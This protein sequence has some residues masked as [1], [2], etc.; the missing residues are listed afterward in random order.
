MTENKKQLS[1]FGGFTEIKNK[2]CPYCN[3]LLKIVDSRHLLHC[4]N[5]RKTLPVKEQNHLN[6]LDSILTT[7]NLYLPKGI[8]ELNLPNGEKLDFIFVDGK[9]CGFLSQLSKILREEYD[10]TKKRYYRLCKEELAPNYYGITYQKRITRK[11]LLRDFGKG[12]NVPTLSESSTYVLLR[13][14][15]MIYLASRATSNTS[16]LTTKYLIDYSLKA[17][18]WISDLIYKLG[19]CNNREFLFLCA[20]LRL[21]Y[22]LDEITPQR[23][24]R[25]PNTTRR[26][27]FRLH[28]GELLVEIDAR[29]LELHDPLRDKTT[30]RCFFS[31]GK[32][33]I[34]F[35]NSEIDK[36]PLKCVRETINIAKNQGIYIKQQVLPTFIKG[37]IPNKVDGGTN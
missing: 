35:L 4:S 2:N 26:V 23:W 22:A 6:L 13:E 32:F 16:K 21:G 19:K 18:K 9:F 20:W 34:R 12:Q 37:F 25:L 17:K 1:L 8:A 30:D 14:D 24:Y 31:K 7:S 10:T 27:D 15:D 11:R 3:K 33:V 28:E 36:N 5:Y 29:D